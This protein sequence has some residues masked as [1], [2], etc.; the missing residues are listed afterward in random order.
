MALKSPYFQRVFKI[1]P[2]FGKGKKPSG[3]TV[4]V[5]P[6]SRPLRHAV[7]LL[8]DTVLAWGPGEGRMD[9]RTICE[10]SHEHVSVSK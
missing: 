3:V 5:G 2:Y 7:R 10:I 8:A 4:A 1:K 9:L 6:G